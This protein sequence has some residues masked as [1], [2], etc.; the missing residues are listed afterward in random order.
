MGDRG[1]QRIKTFGSLECAQHTHHIETFICMT[2]DIVTLPVSFELQAKQHPDQ[3]VIFSPDRP[4]LT[5]A[6]L[7]A[8]ICEIVQHLNQAGIGR[9][10]R[11]GIVLPDGP[12]LALA[13]WSVASGATTATFRT[14]MRAE[15]FKLL[16]QRTRICAVI[17][18]QGSDTPARTVAAELGLFII[19]L[20]PLTAQEAGLF[21][22]IIPDRQETPVESGFAQIDDIAW[23]AST[24]GTTGQPKV[25][26][27]SHRM[28]YHRANGHAL[29]NGVSKYDRML[30][31]VSFTNNATVHAAVRAL[32]SGGSIVIPREFDSSKFFE[33]LEAFQPT[34]CSAPATIYQSILAYAAAMPQEVKPS[35]LR[36]LRAG[37]MAL[38]PAVMHEMERVLSIPVVQG[39]GSTETGSIS[40][41]P[42]PPAINKPG[43]VGL[44]TQQEVQIVD[45]DGHTLPI[46]AIGEIVVHGPSVFSGYEDDPEANQRAFFGEWYRTGDQGYLDDDGYLYISGRIKELINRGGEMIS[47]NG[48]EN[49]LLEHPNIAQAVVFPIPDHRLGED[50]GAAV[51][52]RVGYA[53][54]EK[55]LRAFVASKLSDSKVPR[56]IVF[57]D[58]VEKTANGKLQRRGLSEKFGLANNQPQALEGKSQTAY[59]APR[60]SL[61]AQIASLWAQ[62]LGQSQASIGVNHEFIDLGGDSLMATRLVSRLRKTLNVNINL[63]DIFDA[64]T[65]AAQAVVLEKLLV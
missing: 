56:R 28:V 50:I 37:S 12:E 5:S 20:V 6:R 34:W 3:P 35:S 18:E 40:N 22:L 10:Q 26:P 27:V 62:V 4:P 42:L 47:P 9:G 57:I 46:G 64:S 61:E 39:Y 55:E 53:A 13:I 21:R 59:V 15:E 58:D 43:S 44:V 32:S 36:Y 17:C 48:I 23:V 8:H 52:L 19:E 2:S 14:S 41:N 54:T 33:Y 51:V 49:I 25:V 65:I 16:F 7:Y 60:T 63:I 31:L 38:S 29:A 1:L 24:S 45:N 11:V 30:A